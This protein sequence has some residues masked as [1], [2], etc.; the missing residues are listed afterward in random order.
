MKSSN[1]VEMSVQPRSQTIKYRRHTIIVTFDPDTKQW[2]WHFAKTF[3]ITY[4]GVSDSMTAAGKDARDRINQ[5]EE[6]LS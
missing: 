6:R 2:V 5:L 1:V 4:S 3:S